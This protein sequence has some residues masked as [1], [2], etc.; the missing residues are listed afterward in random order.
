M[1]TVSMVY[2]HFGQQFPYVAWPQKTTPPPDLAAIAKM[3]KDFWDA[4][5]A[6]K[7]VD[8]ILKQPDCE[9]PEKAK[10]R[11]RVKELEAAIDALAKA[12][13]HER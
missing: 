11:E 13:N 6:A 4:V 7:K 12:R 1:C 8:E 2:D 3:V 9:D 10:L 5:E